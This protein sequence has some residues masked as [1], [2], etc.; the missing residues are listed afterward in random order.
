[1]VRGEREDAVRVGYDS[2]REVSRNYSRRKRIIRQT[3]F[4][5]ERLYTAILF[6]I[7]VGDSEAILVKTFDFPK[8][9]K[10]P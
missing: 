9:Q 6:W 10:Y 7:P 3:A 8:Y 5:R 4:P 2:G 1:M